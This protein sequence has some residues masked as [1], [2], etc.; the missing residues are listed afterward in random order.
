VRDVHAGSTVYIPAGTW[1]SLS[2]TGKDSISLVSVFSAPGFE[3]FM[4]AGSVREGE[5]NV[6][7][8]EAEN[9]QMEK[10]HLGDVIYKE[11]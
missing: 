9:D 5:K 6:P 11:P 1:I 2:N 4:R 8:S 7:I 3:D 10:S